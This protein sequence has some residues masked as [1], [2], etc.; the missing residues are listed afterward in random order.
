MPALLNSAEQIE[1]RF[2]EGMRSGASPILCWA[3]QHAQQD[4]R[5]ISAGWPPCATGGDV[6]LLTHR[7]SMAIA[8]LRQS[9]SISL[10]RRQLRLFASCWPSQA[11]D[12]PHV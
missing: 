8:A 12:R 6:G 11:H 5:Q 2:A 4:D 1:T 10:S 3:R 9:H 7:V